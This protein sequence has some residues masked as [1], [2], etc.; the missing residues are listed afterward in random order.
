MSICSSDHAWTLQ[1]II[2]FGITIYLSYKLN[3]GKFDY[4]CDYTDLQHQDTRTFTYPVFQQLKMLKEAE[5]T[6]NKHYNVLKIMQ[7]AYTNPSRPQ[8]NGLEASFGTELYLVVN[9]LDLH[10]K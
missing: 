9:A 5:N 4:T 1:L 6:C 8:S 7:V 3:K 2:L 10:T